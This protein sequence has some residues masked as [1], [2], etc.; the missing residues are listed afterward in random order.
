MKGRILTALTA[1]VLLFGLTG[2]ANG[3]GPD[4]VRIE[5]RIAVV[6]S[7]AQPTTL[8]IQFFKV[9][10]DH[11]GQF[12]LAGPAEN[13]I[14]SLTPNP[15]GSGATGTFDADLAVGDIEYEVVVVPLDADGNMRSDGR[16]YFAGPDMTG[17][18]PERVVTLV[19][20]QVNQIDMPL[21]WAWSSQRKQ[22]NMLQVVPRKSKGD[23]LMS[24]SI[25]DPTNVKIM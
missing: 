5:G 21:D 19:P 23:Y 14:V 3:E 18:Y 15:N 9:E 11:L 8:S 4:K 16:Y 20:G 25:S 17:E 24:V 12:Q 7:L 2:T 1:A 13:Q 22:S 6:G 10:R